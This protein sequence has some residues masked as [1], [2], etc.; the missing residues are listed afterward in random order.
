M[1]LVDYH[2][3]KRFVPA[4]DMDIHGS[5][6][7]HQP[8]PGVSFFSMLAS[9][10]GMGWRSFHSGLQFPSLEG[11][12]ALTIITAVYP[13]HVYFPVVY[14]VGHRSFEDRICSKIIVNKWIVVYTVISGGETV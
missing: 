3:V 5:A 4:L 11:G 13:F 8:F 7:A 1:L 2:Q 14:S 9:S 12:V 10:S 6:F